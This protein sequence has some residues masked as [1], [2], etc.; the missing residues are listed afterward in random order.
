MDQSE[1]VKKAKKGDDEAFSELM[2]L[3]KEKMYKIA[4]AY[5][6]NEQNSLDAVSETI[7]KCYFNIK[8]LKEP[9]YFNTW[10]IKILINSCKDTLKT[11]CKVIYIDEY[12]KVDEDNSNALE[13]E[14]KIASNIDLYHAIDKLNDKFRS[15]IILKYFEDMTIAQIS[16]VLDIPEGTVKVYLRRAIS[17]LKAELGEECI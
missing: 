16:E 1:L 12:S 6:K 15:I 11:S 7:Y 17:A 5:L 8:K 9:K 4:F 13:T 10:I 3:Y 2:H 14:L